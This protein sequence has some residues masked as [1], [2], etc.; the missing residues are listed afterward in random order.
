MDWTSIFFYLYDIPAGREILRNKLN[1]AYNCI[2]D[3]WNL[4]RWYFIDIVSL[5]EL[6]RNFMA[7]HCDTDLIRT[8]RIDQYPSSKDKY[9]VQTINR[10][11]VS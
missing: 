8:K 1:G 5:R 7:S 6:E 2:K 4:F 11:V 9:T 10:K 3:D